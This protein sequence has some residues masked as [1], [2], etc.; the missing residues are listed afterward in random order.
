MPNDSPIWLCQIV[1]STRWAT[2]RKNEGQYSKGKTQ[3][4]PKEKSISSKTINGAPGISEKSVRRIMKKDVGLHPY[5]K[6]IEPLL[7]I[8]QKIK[9]KKFANWVRTNFRKE[10]TDN[11]LFR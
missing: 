8:D 6:V 2:F 4:T 10:D 11:S 7:S 3:F 5:N 1:K 9:R